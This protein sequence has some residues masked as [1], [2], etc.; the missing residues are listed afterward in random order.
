MLMDKK[1]LR[2][3]RQIIQE[4]K[5]ETAC[6]RILRLEERR[7]RGGQEGPAGQQPLPAITRRL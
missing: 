1:Q 3:N 7:E 6:L 4:R 5:I 2:R